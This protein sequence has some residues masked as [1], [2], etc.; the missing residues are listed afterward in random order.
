MPIENI[1]YFI[2]I[3][4]LI[5]ASITDIKTHKIKNYTTYPMTLTGLFAAFY[6]NGLSGLFL[7][8]IGMF[9]GGF[10]LAILPGFRSGGGDIKLSAACGAWLC[11]I[12]SIFQF[13]FFSLL[14][15]TIVILVKYIQREGISNFIAYLKI[16]VLTLGRVRNNYGHVPMAPLMFIAY[17]MAQGALWG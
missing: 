9:V 15:T 11:S 2:P 1:L 6:L 5:I 14:F 13:I 7:S 12:Q 4:L 17:M 8:L 10:T 16:E 3:F